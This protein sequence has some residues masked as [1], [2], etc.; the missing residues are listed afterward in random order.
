MRDRLSAG[1][2]TLPAPPPLALSDGRAAVRVS[3][4]LRAALW[5]LL[6]GNLV[7]LPALTSG[8][9]EAPVSVNDL[10]V[11]ALLTVGVV[12]GAS[13]RSFVLDAVTRRGL[14][15]AAV[16]AASAAWAVPRFGL[17]GAELGFSLAYLAR[18]L[19]YFAI[20]PVV[21]NGLRL[22]D[23][24]AVS[25]TLQRAIL[26]FA[27]FGIVQAALLPGFAQIVYPE[28]TVYVDWDPQGHRL[29]STILDPNFAG[30][31][32]AI[33]L[34]LTLARVSCGVPGLGLPLAVLVTALL[35]TVSRS[36]M[37]AALV[38]ALVVAGAAG[39]SRRMARVG[40]ALVLL[41]LPA[42]PALLNFAASFN[43]LSIDASALTR[44]VSWLRALQVLGDHPVLG[45]GF[46]TYGFVQRAYGWESGR[47]A[48]G[49]SLDGG[50][51]FI[52]VMTGVVGLAVYL[53]MCG[54]VVRHARGI[55]RDGAQPAEH[56]ALAVGA[57][58]ATV[59]LIVHSVFVNSLLLPFLMEPLWVL[60]GL[61]YVIAAAPARGG[62]TPRRS[63]PA[64]R[65]SRPRR[66][67]PARWRSTRA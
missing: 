41:S 45:I 37:L 26:V 40:A 61:V 54:R 2:A 32:I 34:V 21:I 14:L 36:S 66:R 13:A 42:L 47:G 31:F 49:F 27:A 10:A 46:N 55:W 65:P 29:V 18:W 59:A 51:L 3:T 56:R 57:V 4:V 62:A 52:A 30:G 22:A 44:V 67:R 50:L 7:R 58:A 16:G 38:G 64:R 5:A 23:V 6:A 60:W 19:A 33:G 25:A 1:A 35:L 20:Y 24:A 12:A 9:R 48:F 63:P 53:G 39:L 43:K 17:S 8:A 15:F 11:L 28:S